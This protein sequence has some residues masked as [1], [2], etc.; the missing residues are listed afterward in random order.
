MMHPVTA[1]DPRISTHKALLQLGFWSAVLTA[2]CSSVS[3]AIGIT[4]PPVSGPFCVSSCVTYPYAGVASLV[5]HDYIWMYPA[6]LVA[7]LFLILMVCIH[8]NAPDDKKLFSQIGLSFAVIYA[9][10][11][12]FDYF[13]QL[14]VMQ[15][16]L[17]KGE[18]EGLALFSMYNP[19]GIFIALEDLGYLMLSAVFL[20][21][22]SVF[23]GNDRL[24]R[25]L[26]W[27]FRAAAVLGIGAFVVLS[28]VYGQ[29]LEYRFEI[30]AITINWTALIVGGVLLSVFFWRAARAFP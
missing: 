21:T 27:L 3:F 5:P 1:V 26:R 2:V 20:F 23:A 14:S 9:A 22:A 4:T 18:T 12:S 29:D 10:L 11:I 30:T 15:P 17:L 6:F 16:S 19:H 7:P 25:A 24:A 13:V 8:H 28:L